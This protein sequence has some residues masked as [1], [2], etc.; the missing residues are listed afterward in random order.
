MSNVATSISGDAKTPVVSKLVTESD[1]L[2]ARLKAYEAPPAEE[3]VK[4]DPEVPEE[5]EE[6][7]EK[8]ESDQPEEVVEAATEE[9]KTNDQGKEADV[10]SKFD[11]DKLSKEEVNALAEKLRSKSVARYGELTNDKKALQQQVAQLQSQLG[12]IQQAAQKPVLDSKTEIPK[13]IA[14]LSSPEEIRA[15]FKQAEDV[16]EW[17]EQVLD[18]TDGMGAS[19]VAVAV[20]GKEYTKAEVREFKREATKVKDKYLPAQVAELQTKAQRAA[21]KSKYLDDAK[22]E[23]DWLNDDES[24]IK[25]NFNAIAAS[26]VMMK[27]KEKVPEV[28]H[29]LD[30]LLMHALNSYQGKRYYSMANQE[31]GKKGSPSKITP[32]GAVKGQAA[33]RNELEVKSMKELETKVKTKGSYE[34][35]FALRV[36]QHSMKR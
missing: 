23:L 12:Q 3:E 11:L 7:P 28:E 18:S 10:L 32:P 16:I 8:P 33:G 4:A 24:E 30:Y 26:P 19:D 27:I 22:K 5:A 20:N 1:F 6:S 35:L 9:A 34:D 25:K 21:L 36:K 17:A 15:K 31:T 14:A 13:E 2:A 29:E